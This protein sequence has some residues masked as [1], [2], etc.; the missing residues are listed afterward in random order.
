M[1]PEGGIDGVLLAAAAIGFH[2]GQKN[3]TQALTTKASPA[4]LIGEE[5]KIPGLW[6]R[7]K[8]ARLMI[9]VRLLS[10]RL[11]QVYRT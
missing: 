3:V 9:K 11:L 6:A 1:T 8:Y 5:F 7:M 4:D 2:S 10:S